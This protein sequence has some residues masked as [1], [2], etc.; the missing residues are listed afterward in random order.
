[1]GAAAAAAISGHTGEVDILAVVQHIVEQLQTTGCLED[2]GAGSA[3]V[4]DLSSRLAVAV[5]VEVD[6]DS[7]HAG[8]GGDRKSTRLNSS[9]IATSRMPSSA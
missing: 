8:E 3:M 9:H 1:M 2:M 5:K 6:T 4:T 7:S